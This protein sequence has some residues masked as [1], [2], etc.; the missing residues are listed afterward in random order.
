MYNEVR[1][2]KKEGFGYRRIVKIISE[3]YKVQIS[4][5]TVI[6]WCKDQA[7]PLKKLNLG[8]LKPSPELSYLVGAFLGDGD[9]FYDQTKQEYRV[10]I[11][12]KDKEFADEIKRCAEKLNFKV[13]FFYEE[14]KTRTDRWAVYI[15]SKQLYM[16]LK[17][18][19]KELLE[20]SKPY[21]KDFLRGFYDA[22][23]YPVI[24]A[25][26]NG[27]KIWIELCN[28]NKEFLDTIAKVFKE[29]FDIT[30]TYRIG[31]KEGDK[32]I[33]R[34]K[35]YFSNFTVYYLVIRKLEDIY[36]FYNEIGFTIKRKQEK[37]AYVLY[38]LLKY[39]SKTALEK[40]REKF[41][42]VGR[43]YVLKET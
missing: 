23:G 4:K 2:L 24:C 16:F 25:S 21:L 10:R 31:V 28:T 39:D 22:E 20:T 41:I 29:K 34:G 18:D 5:A 6:R 32:I 37:L 13:H 17:K 19:W 12:V 1:S 3:R 11:R 8:E 15:K 43:E 33:A 38:L 42:K 40:F 27:L 26:K 35:E 7:D 30:T 36:K 9:L 14:D